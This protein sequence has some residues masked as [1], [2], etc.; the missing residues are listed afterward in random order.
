MPNLHSPVAWVRWIAQSVKRLVV[1]VVGIAFL[2]AGF[3]MIPLPGPGFL[4]ILIGFIVLATE[5]VWAERALDRVRG[6]AAAAAGALNEQRISRAI[7]A[8]TGVALIIGGGF[9]V[10]IFDSHRVLG[11]S[12]IFAGIFGL[13][14]LLP[15]TVRMLGSGQDVSDDPLPE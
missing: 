11:A 14:V 1:L 5:F 6:R 3:A 15:W 12:V 2:G 7:A 9:T 4:V 10:V 13:V 8:V